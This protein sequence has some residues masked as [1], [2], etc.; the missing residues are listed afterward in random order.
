[1][2]SGIH[3]GKS[4]HAFKAPSKDFLIIF[5]VIPAVRGYTHSICLTL[6]KSPISTTYFG[7]AI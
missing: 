1:M 2:S 3:S 5:E 4:M 7:C 6:S